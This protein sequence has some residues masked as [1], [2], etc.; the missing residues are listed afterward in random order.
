ME[1]NVEGDKKPRILS[2]HGLPEHPWCPPKPVNKIVV[3]PI[4]K[5]FWSKR[6]PEYLEK[7]ASKP[8]V[9]PRE[10]L[11]LALKDAVIQDVF[12]SM[13][14]IYS[15]IYLN[16]SEIF[17]LCRYDW[18]WVPQETQQKVGGH[19]R[20]LDDHVWYLVIGTCHYTILCCG[21]WR[22]EF[23]NFGLFLFLE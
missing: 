8:P 9:N 4:P 21:D 18:R 3:K 15:F 13:G 12:K 17:W 2:N 22:Y 10:Q 16:F 1:V 23:P 7:I 5:Y 19:S 6:S 11:N 14:K 20:V